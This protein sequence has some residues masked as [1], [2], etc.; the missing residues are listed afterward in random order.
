MNRFF[1][2]V[3]CLMF[4][5]W[6]FVSAQALESS[7]IGK[8][9]P[10]HTKTT[11]LEH[12]KLKVAIDLEKEELQ[13]EAWISA[14]PYF[15]PSDSLVLN[16]K[17]MLIHQVS[18]DRN[19]NLKPLNFT[20][21]D[22]ILKI[23]LDK[24]YSKNE[25]YTVYVKYTA[26]P[27]QILQKGS[28]AIS[29]AKG[30]YFINARGIRKDKPTQI[31]TQGETEAS[32]VWFPTID[33]PNI[34]TTQEIYI[35]VPNRFLTLSN[36]V[37]K[38]SVPTGTDLRTDHWVLDKKHA[39]YLFFM[40][41]GEY[42]VVKDKWRNIPVDYYVEKKYESQAKGIFGNTPEM[43]EFFSKRLNYDYPWNKYAQMTARDYVSGAMENTT[44]VLHSDM[45]QQSAAALAD[46]NIW[47]DVI[48]H[49]VFHHWFGNIVTT[50]SWSNLSVNESFANYSEYLWNEHKYGQDLADYGLNK[51]LEVYFRDPSLWTKDLVRFNYHSRED[52][53]DAVSYN[54]GGGVLHMLR[55]FLGDDA[56][57][58][59]LHEYLRAN[60]YSTGE[61]HQV[62]LA[63]EKITGRDLNW[64]FN[65]WF[66]GS[67]HP[68][69]DHTLSYEPIKKQV[70]LVIRQT[71]N[72][73]L[74]EFPL[75]VDF[76]LNGKAVRHH[77]WV[78]ASKQNE[79]AIPLEKMADFVVLNPDGV[80]LS[81]IKDDKKPEHYLQQF[82][83]AKEFYNRAKALEGAGRTPDNL[84]SLKVF[85][86]ALKDS[87]FRLRT[88]ALK[89][90]DLS[91]SEH[92]KSGLDMVLDLAQNDSKTLV[93]GQ[94]LAAL[95][96]TKDRKYLPL[97]ERSLLVESNA[98]RANALAAI[99][100]LDPSRLRNL[101][102]GLDMR[103]WND[104]A[105]SR[106]LPFIVKDKVE[107]HRTAIAQTVAFY[108]FL[109]FE[110]PVLGDWAK[111][112]YQ[113]IMES[114][115]L[116]STEKISSVMKQVLKELKSNPQAKVVLLQILREGQSAKLALLRSNPSSDSVK[117]QVELL[118]RIV[119][120]YQK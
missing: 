72:Q 95:A 38:S 86:L 111:K 56:F 113:W 79:F 28:A 60:E 103:E 9:H 43:L 12:T 20:Y 40:G 94:A 47:E 49:E 91:R 76:Y 53:F 7:A 101:S 104:E 99:V 2:F 54:K 31:W 42:A 119:E 88:Q 59:G 30:L 75:A 58:A 108:P 25:K 97:Y 114:D 62:R 19:S 118:N 11:E 23:N 45:S 34:K 18:L 110:D 29:E 90:L 80:L 1:L 21:K 10:S 52:M 6:Y 32:S 87:N 81:Q 57:F 51:A 120:E 116:E 102:A 73:G 78:K 46:E 63:F 61:V 105:I 83:G 85:L 50:E 69:L 115:D 65:Q 93:R 17:A 8:Y 77:F 64:F 71:Q 70:R 4:G 39:P 109:A 89:L 107:Q 84:N 92:L 14:S 44:A 55:K 100:E 37:L 106:L 26:R 82:Q 48:A 74:F 36:G 96:K 67:G 13:G 22:D 66:Y 5:P 24:S 41:I 112:G 3:W 27:N 16:A 15:Y 35:T 68:E 117:E 33:K 98:V